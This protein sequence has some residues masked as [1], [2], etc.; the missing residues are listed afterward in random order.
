MNYQLAPTSRRGFLQLSTTA[1]LGVL[2]PGLLPAAD[3]PESQRTLRKAIMWGTL[4]VKGSILEKMQAAKDAGFAGVEP[5][6]HM[7]QDDVVAALDQTGLRAASVC[8]STH[9][10]ETL[11]HPNPAT[12][13]RGLEGLKQ[14]L[15]DAKR[16][17]AGSVL[18]VPGVVNSQV[19]Y[20]DCW[21]RSIEQIR[22][23]IPLAESVGVV[24]SIENVWNDFITK[25][26]E[27]A[28]YLDEIN[29]PMVKWH[30]DIGNIIWYGDPIDW[31]RKLGPR[32]A[33]LHIKEYSRD[34]AMRLGDKG[35]GFNARFLEGANNW[36]GIMKALRENG[37]AGE[38]GI[39][40]QGG[41]GTPE[42]LR[43]LSTRMDRIF[44]SS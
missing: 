11:S 7:A 19:T 31:V 26:D 17:G 41:G 15:R 27:A 43:D 32:I 36:K 21:K 1:T 28:R 37:Y 6:S 13:E 9:W 14:T 30:F 22:Q 8:C 24:I 12:R 10:N 34:L 4:A 3:P 18:L 16:Y 33:R 25:E 2:T 23:A 42:G 5:M 44:A 35:K 38:W 40:E 20:A 29:S 39:A